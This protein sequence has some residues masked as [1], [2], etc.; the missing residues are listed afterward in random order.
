MGEIRGAF[1]FNRLK[2]NAKC[3]VRWRSIFARVRYLRF[4][5]K[6]LAGIQNIH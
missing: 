2:E 4:E 6:K 1:K 3:R 5:P